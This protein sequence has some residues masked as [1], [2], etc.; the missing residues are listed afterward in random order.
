[1][2]GD[3]RH[4]AGKPPRK[5][6]SK[7]RNNGIGSRQI[8][9]EII[10]RERID[11]DDHS[12]LHLTLAHHEPRPPYQHGRAFLHIHA[13]SKSGRKPAAFNHP[14]VVRLVRRLQAILDDMSNT[15]GPAPA[16]DVIH[17]TTKHRVRRR[18]PEAAPDAAEPPSLPN[19]DDP[20]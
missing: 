10:S 12:E 8:I 15:A 9:G 16:V 11:G 1:M 19:E 5:R 2:A 13:H 7:G 18:P 6:G 3:D 4:R 14:Q 20:A 17:T